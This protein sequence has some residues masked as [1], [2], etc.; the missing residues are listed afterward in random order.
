M[1]NEMLVQSNTITQAR[2][3][4]TKIEKRIIYRIIKEIR[5][6]YV[7]GELQSN[8][9]NELVVCL[10]FKDLQ[11]VSENTQLVY[12]SIRTLK[13]RSYEFDNDEEWLILG[14][15]NKARHIK[16]KGTWEITVDREMVAQFV[17]LAKNYTEYSLTVAMSLRSEYSQRLYEYCS[18]FRSSGGFRMKVQ[19]MKEKMRLIKKYDRYAGFKKYVLDVAQKELKELYKQGQCDLYFE[20]SEEKNGRSVETLR[21]KIISRETPETKMSLEDLLY[22]V[23]NDLTNI[24][25]IQKMPKNKEFV[26]KT[27]T[28][29]MLNPEKLNHC[30]GKLAFVKGSLPKE[31]W[32]RY[33]R[34]VINDEY[35][36]HGE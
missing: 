4:F 15:I 25:D 26:N 10:T 32:Q 30:F 8:L 18:Q 20:Y 16:T 27:M 28:E 33:M 19:D 23:R 24:F 5:K 31:E 14:I 9:F 13:T 2:Y 7:T 21:F 22:S 12:K 36:K 29:L 11:E 17:E 1:E 34:Y 35:F 3:E 6:Q